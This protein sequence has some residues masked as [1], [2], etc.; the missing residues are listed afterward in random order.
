MKLR[1]YQP[2]AL[3]IL[4]H[5]MK[6]PKKD[7]IDIQQDISIADNGSFNVIWAYGERNCV[8]LG[9]AFVECRDYAD[10]ARNEQIAL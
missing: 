7:Y 3:D 4:W 8:K 10:P 5:A 2:T 9:A 1:K 6:P